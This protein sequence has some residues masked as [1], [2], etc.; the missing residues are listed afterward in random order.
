[1]SLY[2]YTEADEIADSL[3]RHIIPPTFADVHAC[4]AWVREHVC[5]D[6]T[7]QVKDNVAEA[8]FLRQREPAT[9]PK[10]SE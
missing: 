1:M 8:V 5:P 3:A 9:T 6:E 10:A 4:A 2:D 7:E